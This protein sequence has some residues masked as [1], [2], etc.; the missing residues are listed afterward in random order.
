MRRAHSRTVR[1]RE[2]PPEQHERLA[3]QGI[4]LLDEV[5]V[6]LDHQGVEIDLLSRQRQFP[7]DTNRFAGGVGL[8]EPD[9]GL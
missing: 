9:H 6:E 5:I 3:F 7:R 4:A 1:S 8:G 2:D